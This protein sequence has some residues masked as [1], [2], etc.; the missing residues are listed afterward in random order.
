[1]HNNHHYHPRRRMI[2]QLAVSPDLR[3]QRIASF[4]ALTNLH[5][6]SPGCFIGLVSTTSSPKALQSPLR[7]PTLSQGPLVSIHPF[8]TAFSGPSRKPRAQGGRKRAARNECRAVSDRAPTARA[9]YAARLPFATFGHFPKVNGFPAQPSGN[10]S[11]FAIRQPHSD[12]IAK[13][14]PANHLERP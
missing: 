2:R 13:E 1:M 8:L 11:R 6:K 5:K 3:L 14:K 10:P 9:G 7:K 12:K 4:F